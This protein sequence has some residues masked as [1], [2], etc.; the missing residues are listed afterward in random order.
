MNRKLK[1]TL[2]ILLQCFVGVFCLGLMVYLEGVQPS[3]SEYTQFITTSVIFKSWMLYLA[4]GATKNKQ[5]RNA[6]YPILGM[7]IFD[8]NKADEIMNLLHNISA[9]SFFIVII[10]GLITN[11]HSKY[12][13]TIMLLSSG[14]LFFDIFW[15]EVIAISILYLHFFRKMLRINDKDFKFRVKK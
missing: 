3:I 5:L 12:V 9:V 2:E 8:I 4:Y 14:F 10:Y 15:G 6:V 1:I 7:A 13:G 11:K